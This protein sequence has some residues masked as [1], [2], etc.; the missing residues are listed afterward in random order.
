M[1][2]GLLPWKVGLPPILSVQVSWTVT[3]IPNVNASPS[4]PVLGLLRDLLVEKGS[5]GQLW[6][7]SCRPTVM[8]P[9]EKNKHR[10]EEKMK[11][12]R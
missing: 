11:A 10:K 9:E 3:G 1:G 4:P 6:P 5:M 2:F 7:E 12:K 8:A